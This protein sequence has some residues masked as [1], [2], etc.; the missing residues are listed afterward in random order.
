MSEERITLRIDGREVETRSGVPIIEAAE[1]NGVYIPR[2]CYHPRMRAVGMCRMCLVEVKGPRG[3]S[4]QPSCYI[5]V[6]D[7]MEVVTESDAVKKAQNGV[8]EFLLANHPL[9]CPVCDRGG[10][11]PLQDQT[12]A[13]GSGETRFIEEK[14]HFAKPIAISPLIKLDRE[15]CIQCDRC[16]RF[17]DEI[18]GEPLI[19]FAD[20]GNGLRVANFPGVDFNSYF[21]GNIVQICPVGALTGTPYRFKA[22]PWDLTQS[23]STCGSCGLG[24]QVTVQSSG[25]EIV[26]LLGLDSE[27]VNQGWLCDRGRFGF[28]ALNNRGSRV[29]EPMVRRQDSRAAVSWIDAYSVATERLRDNKKSQVGVIGGET[30]TNEGAY[31]WAKLIRGYL[32]SEKIAAS[33][34]GGFDPR[35]VSH[36]S[37]ASL[38]E[39]RQAPEVVVVDCDPREELPVLYL[40]LRAAAQ[41]GHTIREIS[42]ASTSLSPLATY[43]E[44]I[45][46]ADPGTAIASALQGLKSDNVVIVAGRMNRALSDRFASVLVREV[47][48]RCG[49]GA[50]VLLATQG[51]NAAGSA[52]AGLDM[53]LY[54]GGTADVASVASTPWRVGTHKEALE[55]LDAA[56]DGEINT[57]FLLD[58][59]FG[60]LGVSVERAREIA[61]HCRIVSCAR[62]E[63]ETTRDIAHVILPLAA[64]GEEHGTVVNVERR[65]LR[66]ASQV[67]P[68]GSAKPAWTVATEIGAGLGYDLGFYVEGDVG[69]ELRAWGG[70]YRDLPVEAF[71]GML[72]GPLLPIRR[73]SVAS[74]RAL[75]P[76]ATPG[77]GSVERQG[78]NVALGH[79]TSPAS[80]TAVGGLTPVF[81]E[82]SSP[83]GT[84]DDALEGGELRLDACWLVVRSRLFDQSPEVGANASFG[85]LTSTPHIA[86]NPA[87]AE[88]LGLAEGSEVPLVT[89]SLTLRFDKEIAEGVAV[90]ESD[91]SILGVLARDVV[92]P[93]LNL[94]VQ[95]G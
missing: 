51:F 73:A 11:C 63:S 34:H 72:D 81:G 33:V 42:S 64:W 62:F 85:H 66:V 82:L 52:F 9:D 44:I 90:L 1:E 91:L 95:N 21:S 93:Q 18:A 46:P 38:A 79:A 87:T 49:E 13:H 6:A 23:A 31:A 28:G 14:R 83:G 60:Q 5:N 30:L 40:Q 19:D 17:A 39:I 29:A 69:G 24:C 92:W 7:G 10:E 53:A 89:G 8:I 75:D 77:I 16:T 84:L 4:L 88:R 47:V 12:F 27:A 65:L 58:V 76:M 35:V 57:L 32:S 50:K 25:T 15:R 80:A 20:R 71:E 37:P 45:D 86:L 22:R 78:A 48:S 54:P 61:D 26:R 43:S 56:E 94:G 68:M 59:S 2:F 41:A 3:F 67:E 36:F 55:I 74:V 70:L